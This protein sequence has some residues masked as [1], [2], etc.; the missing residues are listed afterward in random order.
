M[1]TETDTVEAAERRLM[2]KDLL[3]R[4]NEC[5]LKAG[6]A[7]GKASFRY[8][9]EGLRLLQEAEALNEEK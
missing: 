2:R 9:S 8:M 3:R 7:A 4:A 5:A 1:S 6:Y